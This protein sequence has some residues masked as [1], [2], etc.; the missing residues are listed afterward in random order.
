MKRSRRTGVKL[1]QFVQN[2]KEN[3]LS[4]TSHLPDE[5]GSDG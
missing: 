4:P 3:D 2:G 5:K 1:D